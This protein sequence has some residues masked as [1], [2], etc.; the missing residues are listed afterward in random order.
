VLIGA[1]LVFF[2]F[3]KLDKERQM[4]A[5]YHQTD[6]AAMQEEMAKQQAAP[7]SASGK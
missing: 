7:A 3:P 4:L 6:M 2:I 1:A 5:A